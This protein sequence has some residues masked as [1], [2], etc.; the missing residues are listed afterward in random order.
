[1]QKDN[2]AHISHELKPQ[3]YVISSILI[4]ASQ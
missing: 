3:G 1:M 4:H 2:E